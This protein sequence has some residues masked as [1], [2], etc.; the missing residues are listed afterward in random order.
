MNIIGAS[1]SKPHTDEVRFCRISL[2][3]YMRR[4]YGLPYI[5][6]CRM[7]KMATLCV[8]LWM[9]LNYLP[10]TASNDKE[11]VRHEADTPTSHPGKDTGIRRRNSAN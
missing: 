1:L 11:I 5:P 3:N 8:A 10:R 4:T 9:Q 2:Y 6:I 7:D